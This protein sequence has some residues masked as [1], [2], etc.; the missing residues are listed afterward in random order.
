VIGRKPIISA[1]SPEQGES[2]QRNY[3]IFDVSAQEGSPILKRSGKI[4]EPV[5]GRLGRALCALALGSKNPFR[6][7][8]AR[9]ETAAP[10][11][12]HQGLV[13]C[14]RGSCPRSALAHFFFLRFALGGSAL[15]LCNG[16]TPRSENK[17]LPRNEGGSV[18]ALLPWGITDFPIAGTSGG[19]PP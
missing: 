4:G 15:G 14:G 12:V 9:W 18:T 1:D 19:K 16:Y 10:K 7:D 5:N 8:L 6:T 11:A 13:P 3:V 17:S 2:I